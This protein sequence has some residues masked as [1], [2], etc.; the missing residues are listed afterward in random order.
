MNKPTLLFIHQGY[1]SFVN[2]DLKILKNFFRVDE[3][4]FDSRK[5]NSMPVY[6]IKIT[7]QF[8]HQFIWL[9]SRINKAGGIYCWFSDYHGFLPAVLAKLFNKPLLT[10][11]G[12][13]DSNKID[14]LNYG[15]FSSTWRTHLGAYVLRNS[16]LLL[17][18]HKSLIEGSDSSENWKEAFN[19]GLRVNLPTCTTPWKEL[20]TGYAPDQW[21]AGSP[22]RAPIVTTVAYVSNH[23]TSLIKG[24]DYVLETAR[25]LP[26]FE[27]RLVGLT[28]SYRNQFLSTYSIPANVTLLEPRER[29]KLNEVYK[30]SSVYIQVSRIEG[31]PNVLCEAMLCGCVPVGSPVFGIPS[32]INEAGF[33]ADDPDPKA[34][35]GII[36]EAHYKA[37]ELRE[38]CRNHILNN[39]SLEKRKNQLLEIINAHIF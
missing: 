5:V 28:K 38:K 34:I 31:M 33:V 16:T 23:R 32:V 2:E 7:L 19:N 9:L 30:A 10:V 3:F 26:D 4:H 20:A 24:W 15:V 36:K 25:L 37:P 8:L 12:G 29:S 13:S 22:N 35:A 1:S 39:Y 6:A 17:P 27:F 14:H 21:D 18:V 11:L